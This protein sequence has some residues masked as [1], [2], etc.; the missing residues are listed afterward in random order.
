MLRQLVAIK[1]NHDRNEVV[2]IGKVNE[3]VVRRGMS[4]GLRTG[5]MLMAGTI[6]T[7]TMGVS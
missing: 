5:P 7:T 6:L 2:V 4:T 3:L 1:F